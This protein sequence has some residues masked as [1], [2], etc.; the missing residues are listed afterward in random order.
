[1][2]RCL[3]D[4]THFRGKRQKSVIK[5]LPL[6]ED[7]KTP[8]F[9][10]DFEL[11]GKRSQAELKIFQFGSDLS[12]ESSHRVYTLSESSYIS[13]ILLSNLYTVSAMYLWLVNHWSIIIT[14]NNLSSKVL[15]L[16]WY[17]HK[18]GRTYFFI[19]TFLWGRLAD[20]SG[21]K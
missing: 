21:K 14:R 10:L 11:S 13:K 8:K 19:M 1:M 6:A 7:L 3:F 5:R 20:W 15:A 9:H 2:C 17:R 4:L 12:L 16:P 18:S